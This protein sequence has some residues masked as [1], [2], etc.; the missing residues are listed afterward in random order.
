MSLENPLLAK[1]SV[2]SG[3]SSSLLSS[4]LTTSSLTEKP[5]L[6]KTP[7]SPPRKRKTVRGKSADLIE[8]KKP[9]SQDDKKP[10]LSSHLLSGVGTSSSLLQSSLLG[11]K[12]STLTTGSSLTTRSRSGYGTGSNLL[13]STGLSG[14]FG[15][16][17]QTNISSR[18]STSV[19]PEADGTKKTSF[20]TTGL[21][22][23]SSG[24]SKTSLGLGPSLISSVSVDRSKVASLLSS[25][26][27]QPSLGLSTLTTSLQSSQSPA[28]VGTNLG[29]RLC[30]KSA[31]MSSRQES[32]E[33]KKGVKGK[34]E[35]P[36][37]RKRARLVGYETEAPVY[38]LTTQV[39]DEPEIEIPKFVPPEKDPSLILTGAR[40]HDVN[41]LKFAL[42]NAVSGSLICQPNFSNS[43]D[44]TRVA[45]VTMS[46]R[47]I[48]YDPEFI[49]KVAL[50]TRRQ[51]NI[52]TTGNFLLAMASHIPVC[53]PYLKKYF[54]ASICL[55]SDWIEVAEIYQ[56]FPDKTLPLGSLPSA[57]RKAMVV[58][59]PDFDKY[60]LAKYNK[61]SSKKKKKKR[62]AKK[63][64]IDDA[65]VVSGR[66]RGRGRGRA[67][68]LAFRG[69]GRGAP[70][71][72]RT[73]T[74]AGGKP[75]LFD[76]DSSSSSG[77]DSDEEY[78]AHK[79]RLE[80]QQQI[81]FDDK[82]SPEELEKKSFTLKQLIRKL[83]ITEPV[84][85][86][87]CLIG[88]KYPKTLDEF[89]R[90]RLPGTFEEERA[91]KRMKLPI[92]ETWET[93]V[94]MK[95][96]KAS[97]WEQL[98][99][100]NKL[101]FMAMLRN[102]RNLIKAGISPKH[103]TKVIRKLTDE[104]SVVNSKQFPFRFFSAYEVLEGLKKDYITSQQ[105]IVAEAEMQAYQLPSGTVH[106]RGRGRGRGR[107]RV[108]LNDKNW[109][110]EK[111]KKKD[112]E[113]DKTKETPYDEALISRYHKALDTAVKLATVYNVQP[114]R[115]RTVILCD[116]GPNM[117]VPCTAARGLGKPRTMREVSVLLGLMCK[118]S[119]E[120]C[121]LVIFDQSSERYMEVELDKGTILENMAVVLE[122]DLSNAPFKGQF[123]AGLPMTV[124]NEQLRD[125]VQI[126][127]L[128]VLSGGGRM[129]EQRGVLAS[130]LDVYRHLVNSDLL[131]V[132][133]S[134]AG[135]TCGFASD[136]KPEHDNNIY[137]S[138]FSDQILRFIAERGDGG[139]LRHVENI[140]EAFK[141]K[142]LPPVVGEKKPTQ[143]LEIARLMPVT[144]Q[145][146]S[147]R[148]ARVFISSTFLDM[149]GERDLLTRFVF[150]ELRALGKKHFIHVYEVDLRWGVTEE[151]TRSHKTLELCLTEISRC[152]FFMGILGERYGWTPDNYYVPDTP[153]YDW[154]RAY[155][156]GASV[157]EIEMHAAALSR[158]GEKK[159][160][161]F[162]FLRDSSFES[163][164]P[165]AF[166]EDFK[167]EGGGAKAKMESLKQR[168]RNSG[169][170]VFDNYPCHWGGLVDG[171]PLVAGLEVFGS[172][173]LNNFWNA[174]QKHFPDE[175]AILDENTH[176]SKL[177]EAFVENRMAQFV[178]RK[179]LVKDCVKQIG[180]L[181]TG[182]IALIGKPGSGKSSALASIVHE[183]LAS[184]QCDSSISVITHVVGAAPGSTNILA[185]LRRLCHEL[186]TR[187]G[188]H[189]EVP[190]DFKNVRAKLEEMLRES[191]SLTSSPLVVFI[192]GLD[193][194]EPAYQPHTL[195][196]LPEAVPKNVVFVMTALHDGKVAKALKRRKVAEVAVEGLDMWDKAEMVRGNLATHRKVLDESPFNNQMKLLVSKKEANVPLYLRLACE[197]L[198]VYGLFSK[199]T[200]KLKTLPQ[201]VPTLLQE[202]LGR[203]ESDLGKDL[204]STAMSLL[205]SARDG[206]EAGELHDLLSLH[207]ILGADRPK[208]MEIV[209]IQM[210]PEQRLP[211]A[212]FAHLQRALQEFLNP[213]E[214]W[215]TRLSLAHKDIETAVRQRYLK[216]GHEEELF[217]HR[218]LAGYFYS[219]AD[220]DRNDRWKGK[221]ARAF[222]ELPYHLARSGS[223]SRLEQVIC[224]LWFIYCKCMLGMA[225]QLIEDY[226]SLEFSNRFMEKEQAKFLDRKAVKDY[227]SFVS[228]NLHI[229]SSH[230][231]LT[232]QQATNEMSTSTPATDMAAM[233]KQ[234]DIPEDMKSYVEWKSKS[235][236][237]DP[238]YMTLSNLPEP[239]TSVCISSDNQYFATGGLDC[240]VHLYELGTGKELK[241][242]RGHGDMITDVCFAGRDTLC[243]ASADNTVSIWNAI[244]GHR[245]FT[246]KGHQR[247]VNSCSSDP[248]GKL[249][250]T[251]SWDCTLKVWSVNK[252][253]QLCDFKVG[254]PVNCVSFHPEGQLI[255]SGSWD[256]TLKIW[257]VLHKTKKAVLR[258][259]CSS[260]RDVA[261]SPTGRHIASAALDGD[262]KLWAAYTGSQVGNI[263]GH[264][265][266][267]N[268]LIFSPV[269]KELITVS[270]D[271]KIKVW[272]GN[273]GKPIIQ[274]G[275]EELGPAMSV[276]I[277]SQR[278]TLAVGYHS[279][280]VKTFDILTGAELQ[281]SNLHTASVKCLK[282]TSGNHL[283]TGSDD[284]TVKI[285]RNNLKVICVISDHTKPVMCVDVCKEFLA[286]A[287][288]D[289]TCCIYENPMNYGGSMQKLTASK[290]CTLEGHTAP[291]TSCAFNIIGTRIATASRDRSVR[292]WD[293]IEAGLVAE[294]IQPKQILYD[295][296]AD[297]I[298]DCKWSNVGDFLVTSSND[299]NLKVWD[300]KTGTEKYKLTGHMAAINHIAYNS[301]C[302]LSTCTDGS[303]KMWSH[304]GEEITTLYGHS[305]RVNGCDMSVKLA[306][307]IDEETDELDWAAISD[308]RTKRRTALLE[309][310]MVATC[311]DDGTARLWYPLQA[312]ELACLTGHSDRVLS[313]A[314]DTQGHLC[315][316]SLDKS[317]KLWSPDPSSG[318]LIGCHDSSV[319][320]VTSLPDL[321]GGVVLTGSRDGVIKLWVCADEEQTD[322]FTC[323]L[324]LKAHEKA[325]SAGCWMGTNLLATGSDDNTIVLWTV[326][327][328]SGSRY[329]LQHKKTFPTESPVS[330]LVCN[331]IPGEPQVIFSSEWSGAITMWDVNRKVAT[332]RTMY[333]GCSG[334]IKLHV[335]GPGKMMATTNDGYVYKYNY[336]CSNKDSGKGGIVLDSPDCIPRAISEDDIPEHKRTANW[337]LDVD[338]DTNQYY[339][340]DSKGQICHFKNGNLHSIKVHSSDVTCVVKDKHYIFTGSKDKT[341]KIW[342]ATLKQVGQFFCSSPVTSMALLRSTLDAVSIVY[343][344]QLG[345]VHFLSWQTGRC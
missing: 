214:T 33:S 229:L 252:G 15:S 282:Y 264:A 183:Y 162:F 35:K 28:A 80:L 76:S 127:N 254:S 145:T 144:T 210:T 191:G 221:S 250:A 193:L 315:S 5:L 244:E 105:K 235:T 82:E 189:M 89:Y 277:S 30:G 104:R 83:H 133:V 128:L 129:N 223:F 324:T 320:F 267:I 259:H 284:C 87:M 204:V 203:I 219:Q 70:R 274:F 124:L 270:D 261:Y 316:S 39:K 54:S 273:L 199:I 74:T 49:L 236:T 237:V 12:S 340:V 179:K 56:A 113:K 207:G 335:S 231:A 34:K 197:E 166:S 300:T 192:D 154:V 325:V 255:V 178:G 327:R 146:P 182:V 295:C 177:H 272:S 6:T 165:K 311:G 302:V 301:G 131:Y 168:I 109:W 8:K 194:M 226:Q 243:S 50:Y 233:M 153:E 7:D 29:D 41:G 211:S 222:K 52:R 312:N 333:I 148:T 213:T 187:F 57:L 95:G 78:E 121:I 142:P 298:S 164:I 66:G 26:M 331:N 58:K 215:N 2:G 116:T 149:H 175:D 73:V 141:L 163:N 152:Q 43:K 119:C 262:V 326:V 134:F 100:H 98:L 195:D 71:G 269:G 310:V 46:E 176:V 122:K 108:K 297:W 23:S 170:E 10:H 31:L 24:T 249:L 216:G 290:L 190:E 239:M 112:A 160:H 174:I 99:D 123:E 9:R 293:A 268:K 136:I 275:E 246:L 64:K 299:F 186:N 96:N 286:T 55:P 20:M 161:A 85:H 22:S 3:L 84:E 138:G 97:T 206:L 63:A 103:H 77:S 247:R 296:H 304:R 245:L 341:I 114:I 217:L 202:V 36:K 276:A 266:P 14:S 248:A 172:R 156:P 4:S 188:L 79:K 53:R 167:S 184:K 68:A 157:T 101:P 38:N 314:S 106:A 281:S 61:E 242:F 306:G 260:V 40:L 171:K 180:D 323:S 220:P 16:S 125:R 232:W 45:L 329:S 344:D 234:R 110:I 253:E 185:T 271:H 139:Q 343:G 208:V 65:S 120:D 21:L 147:W 328:R 102:L 332:E 224:S 111:K 13:G 67:G 322:I 228:R 287:S 173:A 330:S 42:I 107:G 334:L 27:L 181:H 150:P 288:E 317:I 62:E 257:D 17:L 37:T 115:G 135:R 225:P 263:K 1:W 32:L 241:S 88:K 143:K 48:C 292:I 44:T 345:F 86:V 280:M 81:S 230:P 313:V 258:G 205:V 337:V 130:Y 342:N 289:C 278:T 283:I 75:S 307:Q 321:S 155:P 72:G 294:D 18:T 285:L 91:G 140:D 256:S 336:R 291:V 137:I 11:N 169:L 303:A 209:N 279:G 60:Q 212:V 305:Q 318:N 338:G 240:L 319:T 117:D 159:D 94:S 25:S 151:D 309:N 218:L 69:R 90:S 51:L 265:L 227:K 238:C 19:R 339:S 47:V 251:A 132:N 158:A 308:E 92:P 196:W 200:Q 93:Q 59:F 201:T 126:D 118:Y 198:R